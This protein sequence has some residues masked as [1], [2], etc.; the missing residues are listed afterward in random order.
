[1]HADSQFL[2]WW[3]LTDK[4]EPEDVTKPG[5]DPAGLHRPVSAVD[6]ERSDEGRGR[7]EMGGH[8]SVRPALTTAVR[9]LKALRC[10]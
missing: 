3:L 2:T 5:P 8:R 10:R 1:M 4:D 9:S 6:D 7:S